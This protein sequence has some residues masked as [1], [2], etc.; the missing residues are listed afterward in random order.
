[1]N[2]AVRFPSDSQLLDSEVFQG[3]HIVA[4]SDASHAPLRTTGRRG[5][6]GALR[7][8]GCTLK[9]LS[10]H[11]ALVSLSSMDSELYALQSVSQEMV[12]MGK[13]LGEFC[14]PSRSLNPVKFQEC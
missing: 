11:Q 3:P 14:F 2:V 5:I 6:S 9:T 12:S 7:F 1:M 13:M 8:Q 10:R 4:F